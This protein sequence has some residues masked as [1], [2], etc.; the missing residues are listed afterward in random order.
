MTSPAFI[1][2]LVDVIN[3]AAEGSQSVFAERIGAPVSNVHTWVKKGRMP[4]E[5]YLAAMRVKLNIDVNWLLTGEGSM[6]VDNR[7]SSRR[8][9]TKK[10]RNYLLK[11]VSIMRQ[12]EESTVKAVFSTIDLAIN[13]KDKESSAG[14]NEYHGDDVVCMRCKKPFGKRV[15]V[16]CMCDVPQPSHGGSGQLQ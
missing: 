2:R 16:D 10:Q 1:G 5:E 12:K 11:L 3:E 6:F 9:Y 8:F 14:R 13:A 15:A 7:S 4:A